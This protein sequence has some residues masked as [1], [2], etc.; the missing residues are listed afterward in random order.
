MMQSLSQTNQGAV[1]TIKWMFGVPEVLDQMHAY[2][3]DVGSKIQVIHKYRDCLVIGT[4]D[5]RIAI[6]NEV[7]DRIKV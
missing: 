3:L 1:Y 4:H 7:A 6:G 5:R 2:K